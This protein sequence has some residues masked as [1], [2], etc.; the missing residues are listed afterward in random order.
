M[1]ESFIIGVMK[2]LCKKQASK[3][4]NL[5]PVKP[6][7]RGKNGQFLAIPVDP[8]DIR[9]ASRN[10]LIKRWWAELDSNQ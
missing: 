5:L 3:S 6:A 4:S 10:L 7:L 9:D 8:R 2:K 1:D